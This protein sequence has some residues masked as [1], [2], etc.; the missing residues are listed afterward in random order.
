MQYVV[1][2]DQVIIWPTATDATNSQS[3]PQGY[4]TLSV[5]TTQ[6]LPNTI[7]EYKILLSWLF[8]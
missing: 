6:A 3:Q 1:T 2:S 5:Q 4:V 7:S 8:L